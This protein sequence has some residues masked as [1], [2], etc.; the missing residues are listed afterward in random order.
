MTETIREKES[1]IPDIRRETRLKA[2]KDL[3]SI[4]APVDSL[5][6][7]AVLRI[8]SISFLSGAMDAI[9][10][11]REEHNKLNLGAK[12][13]REED[14]VSMDIKSAH[15]EKVQFLAYSSLILLSCM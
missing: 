10:K 3:T 14:D 6:R 4:D 9:R 8:D 1:E 7:G 5:D 11:H 12:R 13:V 2:L 15:Y